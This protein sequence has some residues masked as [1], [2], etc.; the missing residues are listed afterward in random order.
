MVDDLIK[1]GTVQRG[2]LGIQFG[3]AADMTTEQKAKLGIPEKTYDGIFATEV[4]TDGGAYAAGIRKGDRIKKVS[5]VDINSGSELQEQISRHKPGD[6][7][8]VMVLR[9]DKPV[10]MMVTLK[11]KSGNYDIVKKEAQIDLL[12]ADF[13]VL[14]KNKATEYGVAGGVVVKKIKNGALYDQTR[15]KDGFI[16]LRVNDKEVKSLDDISN[17][18]G[19]EKSVTISGFYPG[20]DGLYEYPITL[21]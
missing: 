18:I 2:Y 3:S 13:A 12:G 9:D 16:I 15:M 8:S 6:K 14:D 21:D 10:N 17:A 4:P 5:G 20:Y 7:V 1:Y 19:N 11:N